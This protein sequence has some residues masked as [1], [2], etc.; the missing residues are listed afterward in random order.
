MGPTSTNLPV[1]LAGDFN[2]DPAVNGATYGLL[3]GGGFTDLWSAVGSGPGF[4]WA[5]SGESPALIT[6]PT[7]RVDYV[8]TRGSV[9][10]SAIDIIGEDKA[11]DLTAPSSLRPSDHAGLVATVVL[12]P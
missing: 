8:M 5:L 6:D 4:T 12:E 11:L 10:P 9:T 7:Q 1:I 3:I 2:S